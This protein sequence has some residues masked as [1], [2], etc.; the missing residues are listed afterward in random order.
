[1]AEMRPPVF[2][3]FLAIALISLLG[4]SAHVYGYHSTPCI[5]LAMVNLPGVLFIAWLNGWPGFGAAIL[6]N[7]IIY[8][9]VVKFVLSIKRL[10][11]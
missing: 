3:L 6:A 8:F 2:A 5:W 10:S 4:I 11:N 9:L 7:G 1:M